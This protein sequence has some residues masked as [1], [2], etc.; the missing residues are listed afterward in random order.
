MASTKKRRGKSELKCS[1]RLYGQAAEIYRQ[2]A[3]ADRSA[4]VNRGIVLA[5]AE[6]TGTG[7]QA[8]LEK[9]DAILDLLQR[10]TRIETTIDTQAPYT[11]GHG[12]PP[13]ITL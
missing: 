4:L 1:Q 6:Q 11:T 2:H 12:I 8:V 5:Y 10:G 7:E 3:G 13:E 9:L